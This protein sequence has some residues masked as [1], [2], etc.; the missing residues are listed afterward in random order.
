MWTMCEICG[1]VVADQERHDQWHA[2][3]T[4]TEP[5]PV[6]GDPTEEA[7]TDGD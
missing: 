7:T 3:L 5:E 2:S 1:A 6:Q 4:P